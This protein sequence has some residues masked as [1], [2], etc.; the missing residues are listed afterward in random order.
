ML[1]QI[2]YV[3]E[4]P[5]IEDWCLS[6]LKPTFYELTSSQMSGKTIL[7]FPP[8]GLETWVARS[9][10]GFASASRSSGEFSSES[11]LRIVH[12]SSLNWDYH[13][14]GNTRWTL[15]IFGVP[16]PP[17]A[18]SLAHE[19]H[20]P[21][22]NQAM[23]LPPRRG[24]SHFL[25]G[26]PSYPWSLFLLWIFLLLFSAVWFSSTH[27][28]DAKTMIFITILGLG[29]PK[30]WSLRKEMAFNSKSNHWIYY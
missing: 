25:L 10:D 19:S 8:G 26:S 24:Q 5:K 29:T 17:L 13:E 30:I 7:V 2:A 23:P 9:W 20:L 27:S 28:T 22:P 21:A 11:S 14:S 4:K 18:V 12:L 15:Q 6:Y 1:F 16:S 3:Y